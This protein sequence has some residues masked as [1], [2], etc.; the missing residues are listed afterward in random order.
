MIDLICWTASILLSLCGAPQ[1][2]L[3]YKQGHARGVSHLFLGMWFWGEVLLQVYVLLKHGLDLP[4]LVNYWVN[5]FFIL[6][7]MKYKYIERKDTD[8]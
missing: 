3:C 4:L 1:A 7:I 8:L 6:I 5:L 2:Y